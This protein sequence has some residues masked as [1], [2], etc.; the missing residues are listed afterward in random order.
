[1]FIDRFFRG[2][3]LGNR[4][5]PMLAVFLIL[6]GFNVIFIRIKVEVPDDFPMNANQP[7][8]YDFRLIINNNEPIVNDDCCGFAYDCTDFRV[9]QRDWYG[10]LQD[11]MIIAFDEHD[12]WHMHPK[13]NIA[14][15]DEP[16]P[17]YYWQK[18]T[19]IYIIIV[20]DW[21]EGKYR[22]IACMSITELPQFITHSHVYT[23]FDYVIEPE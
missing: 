19:D 10:P 13:G 6:I 22:G 3:S 7:E 5:W 4:I 20:H 8:P 12:N 1:M 23:V 18:P 17:G 14:L 11:D 9:E 21:Q 15:C 16:E 2:I